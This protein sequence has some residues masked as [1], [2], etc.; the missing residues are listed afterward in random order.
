MKNKEKQTMK[1]LVVDDDVAFARMIQE[2]L[3]VR[4][5][6][7]GLVHDG[8]A[9]LK[10]CVDENFD[11]FVIDLFMPDM[12]GF[13]LIVEL[14][15]KQ[16]NPRMIVMSGMTRFGNDFLGAAQKLGASAAL[17]KP[18]DLVQLVAEIDTL[19]C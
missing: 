8:R 1:I 7:V 9:A 17:V 18:F 15:K 16:S 13:E 5:H 14:K 4:G 12:D 19:A 11:L 2:Y 6:D 10:K 3:S